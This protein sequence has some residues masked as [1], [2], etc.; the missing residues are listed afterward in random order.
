MILKNLISGIA[1]KFVF[2]KDNGEEHVT[3][4]KSDNLESMINDKFDEVKAELF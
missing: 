4:S 1:I 3:H 2:S